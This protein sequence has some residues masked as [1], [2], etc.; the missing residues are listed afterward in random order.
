MTLGRRGLLVPQRLFVAYSAEG[1][2]LMLFG[3]EVP[4][5]YTVVDPRT[6]VVVAKGVRQHHDEWI[7][8]DGGAPRSY[9]CCRDY[10][11]T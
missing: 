6:G 8:D 10:D 11:A 1:G 9:I 3:D 2:P 4:L 5:P 7:M